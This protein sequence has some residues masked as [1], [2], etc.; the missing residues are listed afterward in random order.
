M[1]GEGEGSCGEEDV[2]VRGYVKG[3]KIQDSQKG[4]Q[5]S[6]L[7]ICVHYFYLAYPVREIFIW[8]Y[9][10]IGLLAAVSTPSHLRINC[11]T[12]SAYCGLYKTCM[13]LTSILSFSPCD[14]KFNWEVKRGRCTPQAQSMA[15]P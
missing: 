6:V 15:E 10:Y 8:V 14:E 9:D 4:V 11:H 1:D 2:G 12:A 3:V 7:G 13:S 5:E